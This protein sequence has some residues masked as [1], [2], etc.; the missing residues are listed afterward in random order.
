VVE[1]QQQQQ[2]APQEF[3]PLL[4]VLV[5]GGGSFGNIRVGIDS[6]K[7]T[8]DFHNGIDFY[9]YTVVVS[10]EYMTKPN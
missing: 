7:G 5:R 3:P 8:S 2:R 10:S 6:K 1:Q 9:Q 4:P